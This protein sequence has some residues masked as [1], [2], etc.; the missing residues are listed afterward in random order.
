MNIANGI[1]RSYV[2]MNLQ[3]G[4]LLA[5]IFIAIILLLRIKEDDSCLLLMSNNQQQR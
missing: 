2:H 1:Q 3:R 4:G 5:K